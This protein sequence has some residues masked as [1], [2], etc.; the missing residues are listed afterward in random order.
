MSR[1]GK[2]F[3]K[4]TSNYSALNA[5]ATW[6]LK[7]S[8]AASK[9]FTIRLRAYI[10]VTSSSTYASDTSTFKLNGSTVKS[11]S[12]SY[13]TGDNLIGIKDITVKANDDGTFPDTEISFYA[14]SYHF[15]ATTKKITLTSD[16]VP[17]ILIVGTFI[18]DNYYVD[19]DTSMV[20]QIDC[21]INGF[22]PNFTYKLKYELD[23]KE[24]IVV[25]NINNEN[26]S[27]VFDKNMT[28]EDNQYFFPY[29]F[30]EIAKLIPN[31]TSIPINFILET[32][33]DDSLNGTVQ[34]E[35]LFEIIRI[36]CSFTPKLQTADELTQRLTG[37]N[38][39]F[40]KNI[41]KVKATFLDAK[42]IDGSTI[43]NYIFNNSLEEYE[44]ETN[45]CTFQ[46]V[47]SDYLIYNFI[48]KNSRDLQSIGDYI[49]KL[50]I[51]TDYQLLEYFKPVFKKISL[52]RAE[53]TA[54][55]V[56]ISVEGLFWNNGFGAV[57]NALILQY[58][59]KLSTAS[60]YT[61]WTNLEPAIKTDGS[62]SFAGT[63]GSED[64]PQIPSNVS[65]IFEIR[66]VDSTETEE[67]LINI[68]IAKE[69][70][71]FDWGE[72]YFSFNGDFCINDNQVPCFKD[73][74][75]SEDGS[76]MVQLIDYENNNVYPNIY[77]IGDI[78]IA[79]KNIDP[80]K[81]FSGTWEL[82]DKQ[83]KSEYKSDDDTWFTP[84]SGNNTRSLNSY[85]RDGHGV[86]IR[87]VTKT[88]K[89]FTDTDVDL[90]T[91]DL[92]KL[93]MTSILT[94]PNVICYINDDAL[95]IVAI[96][97]ST[98]A[99]TWRGLIGE[100]TSVASGSSIIIDA[101]LETQFEY[102]Q[103]ETCDKFYWKRTA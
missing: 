78:Y 5:Y 13:T 45:E 60:T 86:R 84:A 65:A 34:T 39:T 29:S 6:Q 11:G 67:K 99:L 23:D 9:T 17:K 33:I 79:S 71:M 70:S 55:F 41:S 32:Y 87:V 82:I 49:K 76:K 27:I 75:L 94:T 44:L 73:I 35:F 101:I 59:Y 97:Y 7:S 54:P 25:E 15:S 51:G 68:P 2:Q 83:F 53:A 69:Q 3:A 26:L 36:A 4:I 10:S 66:I 85:T 14:K 30:L 12:Y 92:T 48:L 93:G 98:G 8:D 56:D 42:C 61:N 103:D 22:N 18:V 89:T 95:G 52:A 38:D 80:S 81:K 63:I 96:D 50:I 31:D 16:D 24:G 91:L 102:M 62:F 37:T 46:N 77:E 100:A 28:L 72:N 19:Y 57:D 43:K 47:I 88:A 21:K 64:D 40:I 90:G 58:R 20:Y 74:S 1:I